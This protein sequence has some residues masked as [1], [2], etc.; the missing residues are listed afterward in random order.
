[1][2]YFQVPS[3][4][5]P[6]GW[7]PAIPIGRTDRDS[8]GEITEK[9]KALYDRLQSERAGARFHL[10]DTMP[11]GSLAHVIHL[12][13]RSE[14]FENLRPATQA[15]YK[16]YIDTIKAWGESIGHAHIKDIEPKHVV[17]FLSKW[18]DKPRTRKYYKAVMMKLWLVAIEEGLIYHNIMKLIRLPKTG[19]KGKRTL[20]LWE[21]ED[22]DRFVDAADKLNLPNVGHAVVIAFEGFRQ[23]DNFNMQEPRDYKDGAFRFRASKTGSVLSVSASPKTQRRLALRPRE[24]LLLTVNDYSGL[25]W[26]K[27]S[28]NKKF[29]QVCAEAGLDDYVFRQI[30]NSAAIYGLR[31]D[32]TD[33]EFKQRFGWSKEQVEEMRD[34]YTDID[35]EIMD[36][37]AAKWAAYQNKRKKVGRIDE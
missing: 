30:R 12:Y 21:V 29:R 36:Q 10:E 24:Q 6:V 31:A 33:A 25:Q 28:F 15:G 9:G 1:M 3:R 7:K 35:Q 27:N 13:Y 37:A 5:R 23:T 34:Y 20:K 2:V 19:R 17:K 18:K 14:H 16:H 8:I 4:L 11:T 26:T 22:I 32:L